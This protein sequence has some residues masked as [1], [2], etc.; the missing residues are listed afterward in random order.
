MTNNGPDVLRAEKIAHSGLDNFD[1]GR[2]E[3]R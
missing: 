3:A 2:A 1:V